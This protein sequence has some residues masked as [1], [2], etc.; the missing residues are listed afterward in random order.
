MDSDEWDAATSAL[1]RRWGFKL[2]DTR[3]LLAPVSEDAR[4]RA[5]SEQRVGLGDLLSKALGSDAFGPEALDI[6]RRG[7]ARAIELLEGATVTETL[8]L[9]D[10]AVVALARESEEL[11]Y[12]GA[13]LLSHALRALALADEFR[14]VS[15]FGQWW[16][17]CASSR[18]RELLLFA[19]RLPPRLAARCLAQL[20]RGELALEPPPPNELEQHI[21]F[22]AATAR[23]QRP[24]DPDVQ[25]VLQ[26][27]R[28][29]LVDAEPALLALLDAPPPPPS[30]PPPPQEAE[31]EEEGDAE[32]QEQQPQQREPASRRIRKPSRRLIEAPEAEAAEVPQPSKRQRRARR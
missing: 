7:A 13:S 15:C 16:T 26:R 19:L 14:A 29:V 24:E 2:H 20:L 11:R 9:A 6:A 32:G 21:H 28:E 5:R 25:S 30:P 18:A 8:A 22:Y 10:I 27:L 23:A 1:L 3:N 12:V 17:A 31:K 4:P